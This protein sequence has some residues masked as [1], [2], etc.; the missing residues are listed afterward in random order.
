MGTRDEGFTLI[1][2]LVVIM[3]VGILAAIAIPNLLTQ[4]KK[5]QSAD[6]K[7]TAA[8]AQRAVETFAIDNNGS[9]AGATTTSLVTAQ[10]ALS[11]VNA[12]GRL[13]ISGTSSSNPDAKSYV[14]GV[15]ARAPTAPG[16]L[17]PR[18]Q[19]RHAAAVLARRRVGLQRRDPRRV[20]PGLRL[21]RQLV[22]PA[23]LTNR[24]QMR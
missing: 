11:E 17:L 21:G 19:R 12:Q 14:V 13:L 6:A 4:Q 24:V 20:V 9:Y 7:Q 2:L 18:R 22:A 16:F 23:S 3:I 10:P 1:E 5:G 15:R 8:I